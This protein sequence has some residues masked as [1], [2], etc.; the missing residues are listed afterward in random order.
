MQPFCVNTVSP[1]S[2]LYLLRLVLRQLSRV[3][4]RCSRLAGWLAG[5]LADT[6]SSSPVDAWW[7][8]AAMLGDWIQ[9]RASLAQTIP[10]ACFRHG[11]SRYPHGISTPTAC[12]P[13]CQP[14][15]CPPLPLLCE[16]NAMP[17]HCRRAEKHLASYLAHSVLP[18]YLY[19]SVP[20]CCQ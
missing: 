16:R 17:G 4:C 2:M 1:L 6:C 9:S 10:K 18:L 8:S 15:P 7:H 20:N 5:W 13:A 14:L 12:L 11:H 19:A 3:V